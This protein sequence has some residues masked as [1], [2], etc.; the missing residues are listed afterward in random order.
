[1]RC[2]DCRYILIGQRADGDAVTCPE[3]GK[4]NRLLELG[5]AQ[6]DL[7]PPKSELDWLSA[8]EAADRQGA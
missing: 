5:I 4:V 6:E 8:E 7:I 1:V 3:C 2:L